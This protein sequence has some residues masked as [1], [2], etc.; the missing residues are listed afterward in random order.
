MVSDIPL[1]F[2]VLDPAAFDAV[3]LVDAPESIRLA[4]LRERGLE[5]AE[6]ARMIA[7]QLPAAVKRAWRGGHP[8]RGPFVIENDADRK[9]AV[10]K[11][12]TE[13]VDS[14]EAGDQRDDAKKE[15]EGEEKKGAAAD[16]LEKGDM[17]AEAP[18]K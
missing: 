5:P 3:V 11:T 7:T 18:K 2:E 9:A 12:D 8:L 13:K 6:A 10:P 15:G 4:R 17:K 1:L 14:L 16:D